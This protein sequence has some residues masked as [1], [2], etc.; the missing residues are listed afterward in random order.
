MFY[1]FEMTTTPAMIEVIGAAIPESAALF[2]SASALLAVTGL[3]R[4][5]LRQQ[6]EA[7]GR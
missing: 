5:L 4:W 1:L 2:A 7:N 3:V 6:E